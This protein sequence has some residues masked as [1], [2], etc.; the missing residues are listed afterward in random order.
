MSENRWL[1]KS[2]IENYNFGI[3][4]I[5]IDFKAL[6]WI[7][8][9]I[10]ERSEDVSWKWKFILGNKHDRLLL[11]IDLLFNWTIIL[12][13]DNSEWGLKERGRG[14]VVVFGHLWYWVLLFCHENDINFITCFMI[15][16]TYSCDC[17]SKFP[18]GWSFCF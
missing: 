11:W 2:V 5:F 15:E 9:E 14:Y 18:M 8:S 17:D 16:R 13:T 10:Y 1:N 12:W 3:F 4:Y 6:F 7:H